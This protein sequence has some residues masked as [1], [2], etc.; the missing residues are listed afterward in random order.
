[1]EE[2]LVWNGRFLVWNGRKLSVQNMEKSSSIPY[3]ALFVGS[4]VRVRVVLAQEAKFIPVAFF[5]ATVF[6]P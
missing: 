5:R 3:H 2:N 6:C 4:M 1:M